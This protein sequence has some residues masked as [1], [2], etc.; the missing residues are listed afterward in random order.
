[1][2]SKGEPNRYIGVDNFGFLVDGRVKLSYII[3]TKST[4]WGGEKLENCKR[5]PRLFGSTEYITH[6]IDR[7][8]TMLL[9]CLV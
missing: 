9:W 6:I 1:M 2:K 5:P 8:L 3:K 4:Y 7:L